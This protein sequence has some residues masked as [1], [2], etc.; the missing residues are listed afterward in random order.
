MRFDHTT[1]RGNG[2]IGN[3]LLQNKKVVGHDVGAENDLVALLIQAIEKLGNGSALPHSICCEANIQA[4]GQD[5][6]PRKSWQTAHKRIL[7]LIAFQ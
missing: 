4:A 3:R 5:R 7:A 6:Y 1:C 2:V